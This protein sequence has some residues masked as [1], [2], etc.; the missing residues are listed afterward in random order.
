MSKGKY[1][2]SPEQTRATYIL[3]R[4]RRELRKRLELNEG[5]DSSLLF[6]SKEHAAITEVLNLVRELCEEQKEANGNTRSLV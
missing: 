2:M 5:S 3:R 6:D 1:L 4:R